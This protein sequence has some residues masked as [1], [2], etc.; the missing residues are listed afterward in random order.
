MRILT[1]LSTILATLA[2]TLSA[3]S[4]RLGG[5]PPP[6]AA[7]AT[8]EEADPASLPPLT[9]S[10]EEAF[11]VYQMPPAAILKGKQLAAVGA[12]GEVPESSEVIKLSGAGKAVRRVDFI[13]TDHF[14]VVGPPD[15]LK[16]RCSKCGRV[17][18]NGGPCS[19][20]SVFCCGECGTAL[21]DGGRTLFLCPSHRQAAEWNKDLWA[22]PEGQVE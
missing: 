10:P 20:C 11:V 8:P 9:G 12:A 3:W 1:F 21:A 17:S 22:E 5:S 18:F 6:Q 2:R 7:A 15:Q 13:I 4:A 19:I 14:G 16:G